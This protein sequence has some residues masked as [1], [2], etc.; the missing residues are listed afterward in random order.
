MSSTPLTPT[1]QLEADQFATMFLKIAE[2]EAPGLGELLAGVPDSQ[3]LGK[4]EF[5]LREIA[6]KLV[7]RFLSTALE[8]RK[9]GGT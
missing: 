3:L 7:A 6:H 2:Q 9:K 4:T 5:E 8:E 1:Q